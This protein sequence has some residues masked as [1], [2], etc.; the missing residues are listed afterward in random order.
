VRALV[1]FLCLSW[2]IQA[3]SAQESL[4]RVAPIVF[5]LAEHSLVGPVKRIVNNP[6]ILGGVSQTSNWLLSIIVYDN[7]GF[8]VANGSAGNANGMPIDESLIERTVDENGLLLAT[9]SDGKTVNYRYEKSGVTLRA[10]PFDVGGKVIPYETFYE[11]KILESTISVT[12]TDSENGIN[13]IRTFSKDGKLQQNIQ[14]DPFTGNKVETT[15]RD[16]RIVSTRSSKT[17]PRK[18]DKVQTSEYVYEEA[19]L[20]T[21]INRFENGKLVGTDIYN[22]VVDGVG[23]WVEYTVHRIDGNKAEKLWAKE[24]RTIEYY[25]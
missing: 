9:F 25:Q 3:M 23:N 19:H 16:G 20:P 13:S 18:N 8:L 11:E 14:F 6:L 5:Q 12:A 1:L 2:S 21:R 15:Y 4:G 22:Y 17:N 10:T 7:R 24:R